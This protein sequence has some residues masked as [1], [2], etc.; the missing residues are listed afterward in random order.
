MEKQLF[1]VNDKGTRT[2]PADAGLVPSTLNLH[3]FL[4]SRKHV[5]SITFRN[6]CDNAKQNVNVFNPL[7]VSVALI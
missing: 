2:M 7:N 4:P 5:L 6:F 1:N 3:T